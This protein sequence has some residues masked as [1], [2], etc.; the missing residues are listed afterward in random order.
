MPTQHLSDFKY[1][2]SSG[3]YLPPLSSGHSVREFAYTDGDSTEKYLLHAMETLDNLSYD[4][5][6]LFK[7]IKD[8][9]SY[10]H[11]GP[12]RANIF[13]SLDLFPDS[14]VLELGSGC[15]A[16][17]RYLGEKFKSVDSIE[18]SF[19]RARIGRTRCRDLENV[20]LFCS[21][22][23]RIAFEPVY[24]I[25][26]LIGVWEYAS[27]YM[28]QACQDAFL[29][30][31][32]SAKSALKS[33]GVLII[34]IEN[35]IGLKYWTGSP[36]DHTGKLYDSIHGYPR[37]KSAVTFSKNEI[38]GYLYDAGFKYFHFYHCFPDY[39]FASTVISD[40]GQENEM[41]LHNWVAIPF[42]ILS[43]PREY[44]IHE[45]LALRTLSKAGLL[46]EFANSLV[47]V[48]SQDDVNAV[49]KPD[50][51]AKKITGYPR[52]REYHCITTLKTNP[53][54]HIEKVR[55]H[56]DEPSGSNR[57]RGEVVNHSVNDAPWHPGDLLIFDVYE[58][59]FYND[60]RD[61]IKG[62]LSIYYKELLT[63]FSK[64]DIDDSGY[65]LLEPVSIDFMFRN[66]VKGY[67]ALESIDTEW[68][69]AEKIPA[70]Y[71]LFRCIRTDIIGS[72]YPGIKMNIGNHDKFI[73]DLIR[74][75]FPNYNSQR[76]Y[77]NRCLEKRFM[78]SIGIN[79]DLSW[80]EDAARFGV[81]R[82]TKMLG[83]AKAI[84]HL[85]PE[86]V[87]LKIRQRLKYYS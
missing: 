75:I 71:V 66:I 82:K 67:Q 73:I 51:V 28:E 25:V 4:S 33:D 55:I 77:N 50:W 85:L 69:A 62:L 23:D 72:Q 60:F 31:F 6:E 80:R 40:V 74:S 35:K 9:P 20:R 84:F 1:E 43:G 83:L 68:T 22:I 3:V 78:D 42:R 41:Y 56:S 37:G 45:G 63:R 2:Q 18:G 61:R 39:K 79:I 38:A 27:V 44:N 5:E 58:A 81:L 70:D 32:N 87:R 86:G 12:G 13:K 59:F 54:M 46:R 49:L 30:L 15:G 8:W 52:R 7:A 10:Y 14:K 57:P 34:A 65:P 11:F 36:E 17:S 47:I 76:H 48:A 53:N 24:D 21:N 19:M 26:T 64:G 16:I 29:S